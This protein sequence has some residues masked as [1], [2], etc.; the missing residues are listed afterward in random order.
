M[1]P[2]W[3]GRRYWLVGA[4][5]GL[6]RALAQQMSAAGAELILSA[7]TAERLE[8]LAATLPGPA[9]VLPMDVADPSSVRAA[10][11]AAGRIDG[12]V[13]LAGVYTP[14]T[15]QNFD[16]E[17]AAEMI[18]VNLGGAMRVLGH[19]VPLMLAQGA[20]HLVLTGSLSAYRGLPGAIGYGASKAGIASLAESLQVD[21]RGTGILVQLA[22][23]GFIETRLTAKNDFSMPGLMRPDEAAGHILRLMQTRRASA[24][25]PGWFAAFFRLGRFL[26]QSLWLRLVG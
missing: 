12:L 2:D 24:A 11:E 23:P 1:T 15:A 4:S 8:S 5:E 18:A 6:G 14:M 25:F 20:G 26:P 10:V 3:T 17:V 9:Q 16:P 22:N 7:R 19:V 13:W 21:L